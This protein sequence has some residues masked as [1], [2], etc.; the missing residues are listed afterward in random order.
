MNVYRTIGPL[1]LGHSK[2]MMRTWPDVGVR[3]HELG[4][5]ASRT[6]VGRQNICPSLKIENRKF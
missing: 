6:L 3:L 5:S 2:D 1:V 4:T